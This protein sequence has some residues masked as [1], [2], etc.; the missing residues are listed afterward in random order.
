MSSPSTDEVKWPAQSHMVAAPKVAPGSPGEVVL[1]GYR[2]VSKNF[3]LSHSLHFSRAL[4]PH[5]VPSVLSFPLPKTSTISTGST[6]GSQNER[7]ASSLRHTSPESRGFPGLSASLPLTSLSGLAL[8]AAMFLFFTNQAESYRRPRLA[9]CPR[10]SAER[11]KHL[12]EHKYWPSDAID[13][14]S[15]SKKARKEM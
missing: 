4:F 8:A 6:L 5:S 11:S 13:S 7:Q 9:M 1:R 3:P 12:W 15:G 14:Y 2:S 10:T